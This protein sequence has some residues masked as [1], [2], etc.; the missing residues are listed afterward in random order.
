MDH[1][2]LLFL[3]RSVQPIA[4]IVKAGTRS[5]CKEL[6]TIEA[7]SLTSPLAGKAEYM[8]PVFSQTQVCIREG[9]VATFYLIGRRE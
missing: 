9:K 2:S 1:I 6:L 8:M 4:I 5:F 3:H 7:N